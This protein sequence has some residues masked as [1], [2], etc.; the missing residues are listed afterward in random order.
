MIVFYNIKMH[1]FFTLS[2]WITHQNNLQEKDAKK[3]CHIIYHNV[4]NFQSLRLYQSSIKNYY[5]SVEK[6][7]KKVESLSSVIR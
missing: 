6:T 7:S 3:W 4:D 2:M 1:Y 5:S